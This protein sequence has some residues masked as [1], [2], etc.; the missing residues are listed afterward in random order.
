MLAEGLMS[1]RDGDLHESTVGHK[2]SQQK[3]ARRFL[4]ESSVGQWWVKA[5][6]RT[7][8]GILSVLLKNQASMGW[9]DKYVLGLRGGTELRELL[10][11]ME[12]SVGSV[13]AQSHQQRLRE[14][15][16]SQDVS[17]S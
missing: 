1:W 14:T 3:W 8:T 16:S 12:S 17:S 4:V 6:E 10:Q 5:W 11:D 15:H 7:A 13:G 2:K 9:S